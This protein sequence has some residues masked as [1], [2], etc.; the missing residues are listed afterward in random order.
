MVRR[1]NPKNYSGGIPAGA[2][3]SLC[4]SLSALAFAPAGGRVTS[5]V[6]TALVQR[7]HEVIP[8]EKGTVVASGDRMNTARDG[9]LQWWM[10][11]D[12]V[13]AMS[14]LSEVQIRQ[15]EPDAGKAVYSLKDGGL[16][17]ISGT[18]HPTVLT[19]QA[20]VTALGTDFVSFVCSAACAARSGSADSEGLY[21][22]VNVGKVRVQSPAGNIDAS[23]GQ[24]VFLPTQG[25]PGLLSSL[26]AFLL[27]AMAE[28]QIDMGA[29]SIDGG[30]DVI[31]QPIPP[32]EQPGS[33]S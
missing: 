21:V 32:G 4:Q 30:A 3:P 6:G 7:G 10:E 18:V 1:I 23:A 17:I 9:T 14:A 5:A 25:A 33:P 29:L 19:P 8:V 28:M 27:T 24:T 16:R 15:F 13:A 11:D 26:P 2:T 12:S 20:T 22:S 31:V